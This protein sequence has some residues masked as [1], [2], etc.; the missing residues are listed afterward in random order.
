[1]DCQ[2]TIV[3]SLHAQQRA[4]ERLALTNWNVDEWLIEHFFA[5]CQ[6][7]S[8]FTA[9]QQCMLSTPECRLIFNRTIN[10]LGG[11]ETTII[12]VLPP[13]K[14]WRMSLRRM[15]QADWLYLVQT[16]RDDR[17]HVLPQLTS[18]EPACRGR[19]PFRGLVF[20]HDPLTAFTAHPAACPQCLRQLAAVRNQRRTYQRRILQRQERHRQLWQQKKGTN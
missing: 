10:E 1:M 14:A 6:Y 9:D 16:T 13:I 18:A 15:E 20:T 17:M 8:V 4:V 7:A 19:G 5:Y 3:V 11:I 2:P 12:T